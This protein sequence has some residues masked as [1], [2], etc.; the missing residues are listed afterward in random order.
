MVSRACGRENEFSAFRLFLS[1]QTHFVPSTVHAHLQVENMKLSKPFARTDRM[2]AIKSRKK[3]VTLT[4]I[5]YNNSSSVR[6]F[7]EKAFDGVWQGQLLDV[8]DSSELTD[9]KPTQILQ[10]THL[11]KA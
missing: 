10:R 5:V 1:A 4:T 11:G 3:N 8:V 7:L 9:Q 2:R 6:A